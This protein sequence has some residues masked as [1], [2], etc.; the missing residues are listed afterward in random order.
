MRDRQEGRILEIGLPEDQQSGICRKPVSTLVKLLL[1]LL[2]IPLLIV[3]VAR[4]PQ[5]IAHLV[6]MVFTLGAR[7]LN[8]TAAFLDSLLGAHSR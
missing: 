2:V 6:A 3:M 1:V 7:L 4:D 8:A 5:G